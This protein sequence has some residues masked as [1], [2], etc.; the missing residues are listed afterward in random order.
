MR[1]L[2]VLALIVASPALATGERVLLTGDGAEL[3]RDSLCVSMRCVTSGPRD[4]VVS[5]KRV[6]VGLE[7]TVRA[8]A[9]TR[10]VHL[11][12]ASAEGAISSIELMRAATLVVQAIEAPPKRMARR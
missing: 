3:L 2:L 9:Q 7:V 1:P 12:R 11:S 4:V 6:G 10:L 8:G 5:A